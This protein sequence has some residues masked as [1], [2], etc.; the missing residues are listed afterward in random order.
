MLRNVSRAFHSAG[1]PVVVILNV[2]GAIE[3]ETWD[4]LADAILLA[5]QPGMEGGNAVADVLTGK[6]YPSGKL[7]MTF[8]CECTFHQK[9]PQRLHFLGR[10]NH[11]SRAEKCAALYSRNPL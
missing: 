11:D 7:P 4:N 1:K 2:G 9:L 5:W 6:A 10:H 3:T 8:P